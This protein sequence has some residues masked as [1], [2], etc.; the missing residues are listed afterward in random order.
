MHENVT[1]APKLEISVPTNL[2]CIHPFW[3]KYYLG[4]QAVSID[5]VFKSQITGLLNGIV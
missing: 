3:R 2:I 5:A 1:L 4:Q